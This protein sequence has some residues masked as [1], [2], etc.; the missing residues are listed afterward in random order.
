MIEELN[1][2]SVPVKVFSVAWVAFAWIAGTV[3]T[4]LI[5]RAVIRFF[6]A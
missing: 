4:F 1:G 2:D 5:I 6:L 3:A